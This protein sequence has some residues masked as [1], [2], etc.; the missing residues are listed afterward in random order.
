NI[1]SEM[2]KGCNKIIKEGAKLIDNLDDIINEYDIS[3]INKVK[4]GENYDN[5]CLNKESVTIINAIK[6]NGVLQ[7]DDICDYTG[8]EI[9]LV[10]TALNELTLKDILIETN[11]NTYSLNI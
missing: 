1:N 10:N 7:I 3:C 11:N 9:K 4:F 2:S 5:I 6:N 8:M